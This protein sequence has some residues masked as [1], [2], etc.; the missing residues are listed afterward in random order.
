LEILVLFGSFI[1]IFILSVSLH[2]FFHLLVIKA[3]F[4][5]KEIEVKWLEIRYDR[6][7]NK[8]EFGGHIS[9]GGDRLELKFPRILK[10]ILPTLGKH[11]GLLKP[12]GYLIFLSGGL[13]TSIVLAVIGLYFLLNPLSE[14]LTLIWLPFFLASIFQLILGIREVS[15]W[16][17]KI[18]VKYG[19]NKKSN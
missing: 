19:T 7:K 4:K 18:E 16:F 1:I 14:L 12:F 15:S 9:F 13:G 2:E 5:G 17:P 8:L 11:P 10:P 3:L 6:A